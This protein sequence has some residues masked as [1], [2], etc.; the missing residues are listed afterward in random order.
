[1]ARV[2]YN[3]HLNDSQGP[4]AGQAQGQ[5]SQQ[6]AW[7]AQALSWAQFVRII[8][9]AECQRDKDGLLN[10]IESLQPV[11]FR[12]SGCSTLAPPRVLAG[13]PRLWQGGAHGHVATGPLHTRANSR[14]DR[15][16][17]LFF[18]LLPGSCQELNAGLRGGPVLGCT[19]HERSTHYHPLITVLEGR[20][21]ESDRKAPCFDAAQNDE[22]QMSMVCFC[23]RSTS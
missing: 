18:A 19:W 7:R 13:A 4:F 10:R 8:S 5:T 15:A 20:S 11:F 9:T 23:R 2:K 22:T 21:V 16:S 3:A 17:P 1:M 6:H 14:Q 12:K